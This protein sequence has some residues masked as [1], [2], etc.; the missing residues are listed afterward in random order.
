MG[1]PG[2]GRALRGQRFKQGVRGLDVRLVIAEKRCLL[3][4]GSPNQL[5]KKGSGDVIP[6]SN[7]CHLAIDTL[8]EPS[9]PDHSDTGVRW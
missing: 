5:I 3:E 8:I 6:L 4:V 2:F 9:E 7:L 1:L